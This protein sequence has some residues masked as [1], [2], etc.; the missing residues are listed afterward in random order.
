VKLVDESDLNSADWPEINAWRKEQRA[1]I[2]AARLALPPAERRTLR[3]RVA[4]H[5]EGAFPELDG[6]PVGFYWPLRGEL[7][8][9]PMLKRHVAAGGPAALPVVVD[10]QGPVEWRRWT[11]ATKMEPGVWNIPVPAGRDLLEPAALLVPL[12]G[13]D[14][15]GYRLGNGGGYYDRTLAA[16]AARPLTI[17][18]GFELGRLE[19]IHPQPHDIPLDA[20]VTETGL[21]WP[22]TSE[23]PD[24]GSSPVCYADEAAPEYFGYLSHAETV[25]LLRQFQAGFR[26]L[27]A[28]GAAGPVARQRAHLR[29]GALLARLRAHLDDHDPPEPLEPP[30]PPE[31]AALLRTVRDTLP[32]VRDATVHEGLSA[33][34]AMQDAAGGPPA[35]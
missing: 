34:L 23:A 27:L 21:H 31:R 26:A 10:R 18:L 16:M 9:L 14:A 5:V 13:F 6:L 2:R 15:A 8:M 19:T 3:E 24:G 28:Q 30:E 7:D 4:A 17:G 22:A 35:I 12:L 29:A 20:I 33:L 25:A 1:R 11:P 32:R